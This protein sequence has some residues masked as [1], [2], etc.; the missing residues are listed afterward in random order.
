M[1]AGRLQLPAALQLPA[2]PR[3][4]LTIVRSHVFAENQNI[5]GFDNPGKSLYTTVREFVENSL[6]AAESIRALPDIQL[7]IEEMTPAEF[8]K[9][10]GI[11]NTERTDE[12]LYQPEKGSKKVVMDEPVLQGAQHDA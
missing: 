8:N 1:S 4:S 10:Q 2:L 9:L 3:S 7:S 11:H 12:D 6:D 5:A